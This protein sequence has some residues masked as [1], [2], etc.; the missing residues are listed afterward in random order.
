MAQAPRVSIGLPVYNG[1]RYLPTAIDS[2]LAQT[3]ED[4]ELI[5]CDNASTDDTEAI[6]RRY[7][8]DDSRVRYYRHPEN[9]GAAPNY[10]ATLA[11]ARAPY[12]RWACHDD[13]LA[14][15][16]LERCLAVMEQ[17]PAVVLAAPRVEVID[18][19][20]TV[21]P[22]QPWIRRL[23]LRS[24]NP[25]ERLAG[26]FEAYRWGGCG[27]QL[28][29]LMRTETL[30]NTAQHGD[31][32][33]ADFLVIAEMAL[34]G[35]V[36]EVDDVL[37]QKRLHPNNSIQGNNFEVEKVA[38]WFNPKHKGTLPWLEVRWLS[39]FVKAIARAPMTTGERLSCYRVLLR[40][41]AGPHARKIAKE[42]AVHLIDGAT[43]GRW[44]PAHRVNGFNTM[45]EYMR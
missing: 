8:E 18:E 15:T 33:S 37:F 16:N 3:V 45:Y 21:L 11:R 22:E 27:T 36:A 35:L 12:F 28:F 10:N 39:E 34:A 4:I 20:G 29:G 24:P 40:D 31:Y 19:H 25:A 32:P 7:A 38:A 9:L 23:H 1:A 42:I 5:I 17:N 2:I 14:P 26:F 13:V 6:C 41:Y 44:R 30:R 43:L